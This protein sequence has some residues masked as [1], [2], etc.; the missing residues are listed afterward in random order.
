[1]ISSK[2]ISWQLLIKDLLFSRRM[3]W[4]TVSI[5]LFSCHYYTVFLLLSHICWYLPS[6][7]K[8]SLKPGGRY[9]E[10]I[11]K[12]VDDSLEKKEVLKILCSYFW[13]HNLCA[14]FCIY[15]LCTN[16]D[17]KVYINKQKLYMQNYTQISASAKS[18]KSVMFYFSVIILFL[19]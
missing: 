10:N 2:A 15:P 18:T 9:K 4:I 5:A 8:F 1:M 6:R 17:V 13:L 12:Y 3:L 7:I 16:A 11:F 14:K 19:F